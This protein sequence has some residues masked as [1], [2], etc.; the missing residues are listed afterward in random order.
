VP[1]FGYNLYNTS[2]HAL[3]AKT[4]LAELLL[5][6]ELQLAAELAVLLPDISNST[7]V[8]TVRRVLGLAASY[9]QLLA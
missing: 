8:G 4:G 5:V 9:A 7:V 3:P 6:P 2:D 1:V